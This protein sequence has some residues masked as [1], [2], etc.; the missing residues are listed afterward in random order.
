MAGEGNAESG[1]IRDQAYLNS[2]KNELIF[3]SQRVIE[4]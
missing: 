1:Q 2:L 4:E 3:L